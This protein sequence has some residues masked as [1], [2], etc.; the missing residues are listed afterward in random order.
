MVDRTGQASLPQRE[1]TEPVVVDPHTVHAISTDGKYPWGM[2][3]YIK[4]G[5]GPVRVC[6]CVCVCVCR[7]TQ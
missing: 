5:Y 1:N 4:Y 7:S 3:P 6:V 2:E